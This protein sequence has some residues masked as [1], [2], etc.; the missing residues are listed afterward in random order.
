MYKLIKIFISFMIFH[1]TILSHKWLPGR[2]NAA[3]KK[4]T[5]QISDFDTRGI[6]GNAVDGNKHSTIYNAKSCAHTKQADHTWWAVDLGLV[7]YVYSVTLT[8]RLEPYSNI[9]K[10]LQ[11]FTISGSNTSYIPGSYDSV[12]CAFQ[13]EPMRNG[14]TKNFPCLGEFSARFVFIT[15]TTPM[16]ALTLCEV[17]VEARCADGFYGEKCSD[18]CSGNC[19][20]ERSCNVINGHCGQGIYIYIYIINVLLSIT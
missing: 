13:S 14:E 15:K 2:F 18:F 7:Y 17:E 9:Y 4:S 10:R 11:N 16:Q 8:N 12:R 5:Y 19:A 6:S 1:D 3:F 20:L